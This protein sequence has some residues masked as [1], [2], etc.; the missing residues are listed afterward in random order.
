MN[1]IVFFTECLINDTSV[2][3]NKELTFEGAIPTPQQCIL[4]AAPEL[5][6]WSEAHPGWVVTKFG[7]KPYVLEA[8]L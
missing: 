6:K 1:F 5:A 7:C 2:C 8:D 4:Y 3:R